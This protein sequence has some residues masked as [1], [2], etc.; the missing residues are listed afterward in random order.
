MVEALL[1]FAIPLAACR[2]AGADWRR[3]LFV[4]LIALVPDLDVLFYVHRSESH[5]LIV[6][7]LIVLPILAITLVKKQ[8][9][10][11]N[12]TVL[13]AFG[14][15]M[16]LLLDLFDDYT[17]LFWPI[18]NQS[19]K[20]LTSLNLHVQNLPYFTFKA[21]ILTEPFGSGVF[22]SID[23]PVVTPQGLAISLVLLL[24]CLVQV[25]RSQLVAHNLK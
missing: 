22:K 12:L 23:A 3:S 1:H 4:S 13:A 18:S 9:I 24:S 15:G 19:L 14:V 25:V 20:V 11:T 17:P 16:H 5:S 7:A 6:L 10:V 2:A 21:A 8:S